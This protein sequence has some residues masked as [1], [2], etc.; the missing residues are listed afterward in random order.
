MNMDEYFVL[1]RRVH[2]RAETEFRKYAGFLSARCFGFP[3]LLG[4]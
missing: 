4:G 3:A 2:A 1:F